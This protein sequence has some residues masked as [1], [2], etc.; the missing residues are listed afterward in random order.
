MSTE[1][2]LSGRNFDV[3]LKTIYELN[4]GDN[5]AHLQLGEYSFSMY[6]NEDRDK[7]F[8]IKED[9]EVYLSMENECYKVFDKASN[10]LIEKIDIPQD[11]DGVDTEDRVI[12]GCEIIKRLLL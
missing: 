10:E 9:K 11:A 7:L 5:N 4:N 12:I 2:S 1:Y 6:N 8:V 3:F